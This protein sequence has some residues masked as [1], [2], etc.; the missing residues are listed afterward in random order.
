MQRNRET[1]SFGA[2]VLHSSADLVGQPAAKLDHRIQ[3]SSANV[4]FSEQYARTRDRQTDTLAPRE[5]AK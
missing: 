4:E 3:P 5:L 2:S 1:A